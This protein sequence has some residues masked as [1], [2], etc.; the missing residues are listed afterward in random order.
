[1]EV[2]MMRGYYSEELLGE[3]VYVT[4]KIVPLKSQNHAVVMMKES[5]SR[6]FQ[7]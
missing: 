5:L 1:M 3:F 2:S 6:H 4:S 7:Y